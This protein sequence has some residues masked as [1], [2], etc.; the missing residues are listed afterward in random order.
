MLKK[1][2]KHECTLF[3]D[4]IREEVSGKFSLIGL[5]GADMVLGVSLPAALPKFCI[6]NRI[7]GGE[8]QAVLK[9]SFK[10]PEG[11]EILVNSNQVKVDMQPNSIGN[12]NLVLSPFTINKAGKYRFTIFLENAE[13]YSTHFEIKALDKKKQ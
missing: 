13:F 1:M 9:F 2:P 10:D 7:S 8:G 4:D 12:L 3:L 11:V 5:Y 6:M